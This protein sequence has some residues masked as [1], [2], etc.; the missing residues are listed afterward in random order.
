[1]T[2]ARDNTA[3]P[4]LHRACC[5]LKQNTSQQCQLH[6]RVSLVRNSRL[7]TVPAALLV[8]DCANDKG[9]APVFLLPCPTPVQHI[10]SSQKC[11]AVK[12]MLQQEE[13]HWRC[14]PQGSM[15]QASHTSW[16][17]WAKHALN[18]CTLQQTCQ[19]LQQA[20]HICCHYPGTSLPRAIPG[21]IFL[22]VCLKVLVGL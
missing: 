15:S 11:A 20:I 22:P 12:S 3:S 4:I 1:M 19:Y 17:C 13:Q 2:G 5:C 8:A 7:S 6:G 21:A 9:A 14:Q 10:G 16:W 18:F